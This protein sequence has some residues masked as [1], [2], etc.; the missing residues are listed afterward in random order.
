MA[1]EKESG[2]PISPEIAPEV[3]PPG[4]L[5]GDMNQRGGR[6]D[7]EQSMDKVEQASE[8]SF[9]ASDPPSWTPTAYDEPPPSSKNKK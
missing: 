9:P 3:L 2:A 5:G 1:D 4:V 7:F 6:I 8:E